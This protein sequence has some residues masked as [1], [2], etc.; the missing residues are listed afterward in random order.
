MLNK[1]KGLVTKDVRRFKKDGYDLDLTYITDRLIVLGMTSSET[2]LSPW[3]NN[4]YE[5]YEFLETHHR[6]RYKIFN[7][8]TSTPDH[9]LFRGKSYWF[10]WP[11]GHTPSLENLFKIIVALTDWLA[12][13]PNNVAVIYSDG[14]KGRAG[15]VVASYLV[16][17][18]I[19]PNATDALNYYASM[20][21]PQ[22]HGITI[23][24]QRR[25]VNYIAKL[26]APPFPPA[27]KRLTRLVLRPPPPSV[28]PITP[29][30]KIFNPKTI[31][32]Q[33]IYRTPKEHRRTFYPSD[34]EA[35]VDINFEVEGDVI[36]KVYDKT[37]L[38]FVP[39]SILLAQ[40]SFHTSM[41]EGNM[42][43]LTKEELDFIDAKR[44][45]PSFHISLEFAPATSTGYAQ[46]P[47]TTSPFVVPP[48]SNPPAL[49]PQ[50]QQQPT[51]VPTTTA[52]YYRG[53]Q[54]IQFGTQQQSV[55]PPPVAVGQPMVSDVGKLQAPPPPPPPPPPV[56]RGTKVV[57]ALYVASDK[58]NAATQ[59]L[60]ETSQNIP[61]KTDETIL[62]R[63][64]DEALPPSHTHV[65][66]PPPTNPQTYGSM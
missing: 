46:P 28:G 21:S 18:G 37:S 40:F 41:I 8:T 30:I 3:K 22:H 42:L 56:D 61:Q 47:Q 52:E 62:P 23:P 17:S 26:R 39:T 31:P 13:D 53:N 15:V 63:H 11:A 64:S 58:V 44:Y 5:V 36:V 19:I 16:Y 2:A 10:G 32:I 66:P 4:A 1:L 60:V 25:Y 29:H 43:T 49:Y 35:I 50:V 54:P 12:L 9:E 7:L 33:E 38:L 51:Y 34:R 65:L 59:R 24:S 14:G 48:T 20:R 45:P 27:R 55:I 6:N 57:P